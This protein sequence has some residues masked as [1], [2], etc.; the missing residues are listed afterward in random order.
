MV[1]HG[2]YGVYDLERGW[3]PGPRY[4]LRRHRILRLMQHVPPG[5]VLDI[6]CGAG[7][8]LHDLAPLGHDCC[9]LESSDPAYELAVALSRDNPRINVF[10]EPGS[11]WRDSFDV[12]TAFEVLEHIDDD[13]AA[14]NLWNSFLKPGGIMLISVPAHQRKWNAADVSAGHVRR[15]ERRQLRQALEGCGL[16]V[17]HLEIYGFPL[18]VVLQR[19]RALV[20]ERKL[21][22]GVTPADESVQSRTEN[23]GQSGIDRVL[24]TRAYPFYAS[25]P[26]R[27]AMGAFCRFQSLFANTELGNGYLALAKKEHGSAVGTESLA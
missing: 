14:L 4:I 13:H 27:L 12:V 17:E 22:H 8:L 20:Y 5:R 2:P 19:I 10:Q 24:D 26:S 18:T 11:Q 3:V 9:A 15:Y 25:L 1:C 6:G 21:R 7:A 23:T 16:A